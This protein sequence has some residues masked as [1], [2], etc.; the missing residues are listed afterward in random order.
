MIQELQVRLT[1][2]LSIGY[3]LTILMERDST[4]QNM[5]ANGLSLL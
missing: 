5:R 1:P 4:I 2:L 3:T